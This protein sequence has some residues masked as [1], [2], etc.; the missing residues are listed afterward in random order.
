CKE[1][2]GETQR[3]W[4]KARPGYAT[5]QT[6]KWRERH[7]G[8]ATIINKRASLLREY[9]ITLD[10]YFAM[11]ERQGGVCA[12]CH[13]ECQTRNSLAVDHCH[14]TGRVRGL[15]CNRCNRALGLL[16]DDPEVIRRAASYLVG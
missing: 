8:A 4:Q 2:Q 3:A 11:L 14:E 13:Q 15:L 6:R 5:D 7:P 10:D 1:C 9:G 16:R 12:I